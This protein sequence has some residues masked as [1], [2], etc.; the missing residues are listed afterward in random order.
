MRLRDFDPNHPFPVTQEM[1]G[2]EVHVPNREQE[3]PRRPETSPDMKRQL[4]LKEQDLIYA[5]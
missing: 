1:I 4:A 3:S 2:S 5:N